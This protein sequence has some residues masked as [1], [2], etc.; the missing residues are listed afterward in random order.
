MNYSLFSVT[1]KGHTGD[2]IIIF[3]PIPSI[4][5]ILILISF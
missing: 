2:G 5:I 3:S 4:N 1:L